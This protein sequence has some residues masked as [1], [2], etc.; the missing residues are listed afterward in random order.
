MYNVVPI[1]EAIGRKRLTNKA[2]A[3]LAGVSRP[4]V[5]DIRNGEWTGSMA[6]LEKVLAQ[7]D[8]TMADIFMEASAA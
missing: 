3:E 2:L 6:I 4:T 7:L 5:I 8:L 1:N